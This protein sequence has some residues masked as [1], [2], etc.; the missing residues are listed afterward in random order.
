MFLWKIFSYP[1]FVLLCFNLCFKTSH[2]GCPFKRSLGIL[3]K[4]TEEDL[5][6]IYH[7]SLYTKG[8]D[9][10]T[11]IRSEPWQKNN[12]GHCPNDK[13]VLNSR[14]RTFNGICNNVVTNKNF[15]RS[16][17][18]LNR[19]IPSVKKLNNNAKYNQQLPNPRKISSSIH[20]GSEESNK[21]D[22]R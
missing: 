3:D 21:K 13:C 4:K 1:G 22:Q 5:Y 15:G 18:V 6:N 8:L 9:E 14:F 19:L 7:Q 17:S 2:A 10:E 16:S 12:Y 11:K 20:G